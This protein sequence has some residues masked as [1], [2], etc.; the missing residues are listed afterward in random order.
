VT[1][2]GVS[3][4]NDKPLQLTTLSLSPRVFSIDNFFR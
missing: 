3:S 1:L 4:A 2:N